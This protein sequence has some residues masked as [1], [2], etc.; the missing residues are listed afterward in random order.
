MESRV[1]ENLTHGSEGGCWKQA[2]EDQTRADIRGTGP[3]RTEMEKTYASPSVP[4]DR[5]AP[6]AYP[7]GHPISKPHEW[8]SHPAAFRFVGKLA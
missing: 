5:T 7:T 1:R 4:F 2:A 6:V 8:G 3:E